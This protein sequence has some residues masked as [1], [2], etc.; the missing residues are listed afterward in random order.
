MPHGH[1]EIGLCPACNRRIH[2][3]G[4]R[5]WRTRNAEPRAAVTAAV[6]CTCT[7]ADSYTAAAADV[8]QHSCADLPSLVRCL[9][10]RRGTEWVSARSGSFRTV[11]DG[12]PA[13]LF[14]EGQFIKPALLREHVAEREN[15]CP[16]AL[17]IPRHWVGRRVPVGRPCTFMTADAC[18]ELR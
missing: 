5:R 2:L 13:R 6:T 18:R 1:D 10:F 8:H 17:R 7:D 12:A 11:V 4:L 9:P 3:H 16:K 14:Y 15:W